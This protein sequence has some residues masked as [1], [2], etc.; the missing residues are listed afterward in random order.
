[1]SFALMVLRLLKKGP[2]WFY[3]VLACLAV[4]AF[5]NQA[6]KSLEQNNSKLRLD[7]LNAVAR[8]AETRKIADSYMKE[9]VQAGLRADSLDKKLKVKPVVQIKTVVKEVEVAGA[10]TGKS[11]PMPDGLAAEFEINNERMTG[12]VDVALPFDT[13]RY[14][15]SLHY[16][17]TLKPIPLGVKV[18]CGKSGSAAVRLTP[19]D[20]TEVEI[21]S[22]QQDPNICMPST[23]VEKYNKSH[24]KLIGGGLFLL[25]VFLGYQHAKN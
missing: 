16:K 22:A 7:S 25:G 6:I 24:T 17:F 19:P 10:D 3:A 14:E 23:V 18:T 5:Q 15:P 21:E 2:F 11:K 13:V 1:M 12:V 9:A 20:G 8:Q 4:M